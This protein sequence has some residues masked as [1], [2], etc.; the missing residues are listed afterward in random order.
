MEK[1]YKKDPMDRDLVTVFK[2]DDIDEFMRKSSLPALTM[3][4]LLMSG[5]ASSDVINTS[6]LDLIK[7]S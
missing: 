7:K 6:R 5:C 4:T 3:L 2:G 1:V